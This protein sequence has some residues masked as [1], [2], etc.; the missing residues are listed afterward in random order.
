MA[1]CHRSRHGASY[2]RLLVGG[3]SLHPVRR[4]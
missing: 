3:K 1:G 2:R 4:I